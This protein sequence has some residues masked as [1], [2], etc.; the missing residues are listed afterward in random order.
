VYSGSADGKVYVWNLDATLAGTIDVLSATRDSRPYDGT[1]SMYGW[2]DS[3]GQSDWNTCV[4]DASFHPFAPVLAASS[5]NGYGLS[6]GTVSVHSWDDGIEEDRSE[7]LRVDD[8]L[9]RDPSLYT[10]Q[11]RSSVRR[12]A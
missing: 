5:W 3:E 9:N 8:K 6:T 12:R 4:R 1:H 7:S 2:D 10:L 11:P